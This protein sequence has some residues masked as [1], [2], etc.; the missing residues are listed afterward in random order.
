MSNFTVYVQYKDQSEVVEHSDVST[1]SL[2]DLVSGFNDT[3]VEFYD[4]YDSE[5]VMLD[6]TEVWTI[7]NDYCYS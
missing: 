1:E 6:G 7:I 2:V 4:V 3:F 5:G